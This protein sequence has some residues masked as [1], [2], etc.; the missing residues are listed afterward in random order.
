[1]EALEALV[2]TLGDD[3]PIEA[4]LFGTGLF[5]WSTK[6]CNSQKLLAEAHH[7]STR[8][9]SW[10]D[11]THQ[12][13][14]NG[15]VRKWD[16]QP[17]IAIW[18]KDKSVSKSDLIWRGWLSSQSETGKH[19]QTNPNHHSRPGSPGRVA[20]RR[21][22]WRAAAYS[23]AFLATAQPCAGPEGRWT[24]PTTSQF[25]IFKVSM[26]LWDAIIFI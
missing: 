8:V 22:F 18:A 2:W 6:N 7:S 20:F 26:V 23:A 16:T 13:S 3:I 5:A 10:V 24:C 1:M 14:S 4:L 15:L 19:R 11:V 17:K 12:N 25:D 9:P 21:S